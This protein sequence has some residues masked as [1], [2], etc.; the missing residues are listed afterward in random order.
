MK[1]LDAIS[2]KL[3]LIKVFAVDGARKA[4]MEVIKAGLNTIHFH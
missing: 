1:A 2:L 3:P 4:V